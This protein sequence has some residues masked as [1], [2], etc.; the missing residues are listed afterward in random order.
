[1][2]IFHEILCPCRKFCLIC[3][4]KHRSI[5]LC[6]LVHQM[7]LHNGI[8]HLLFQTVCQRG[9]VIG[10]F[11]APHII[12]SF[13]QIVLFPDHLVHPNVKIPLPE[14]DLFSIDGKC[15]FLCSISGGCRRTAAPKKKC[16]TQEC[17]NQFSHLA[18]CSFS[19]SISVRTSSV[20]SS[21]EPEN[22]RV[23]PFNWQTN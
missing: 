22:L 7:N 13:L 10:D 4:G 6:V 23:P 17:Y 3:L 9:S 14:T 1:M 15:R 18:S 16:Q 12:P 11:L 5:F 8:Q 20:I 2:V 21:R 19:S